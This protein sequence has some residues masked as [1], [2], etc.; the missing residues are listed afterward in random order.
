MP[1]TSVPA[2]PAGAP[3]TRSR[4]LAGLGRRIWR[5]GYRHTLIA[6]AFAVLLAWGFLLLPP[7]NSDLAAQLARA[8]FAS[9]YP[10]SIIDFRWFG[11][12][13]EY[14]Y[15]LWASA[16]MAHLGTK[17]TGALAAVV[18]TWYTTRLLN[19][20]KPAR[21]V[22]GGMAAAV[23]QVANVVEGRI[24]FAC[25]LACGLVAITLFTTRRLPRWLAV[26]LAVLFSLL[27]GGASPVAALLLWV[28]GGVALLMRRPLAAVVL[29]V[30]SGL[31][32]AVTSVIFG[33][34]GHQPF[35]FADC[36]KSLAA[37]AIVL[38]TVPRRCH[39][40][41]LGAGIGMLLL[42]AAFLLPTPV[43]S[44]A[45]RLGVLFALPVAAAFVHWHNRLLTALALVGIV[46]LQLPVN[47]ATIA[48]T[49]RVSGYSAYYTALSEEIRSRGALTGRVEV[50]EMAG[51]WDSVYLARGVPL[52]RGWL[53]QTDVR[54]NDA[55]FYKRKPTPESYRQFLTDNAVQYVAVPDAELTA[56]GRD[57][58]ALIA[59]NL[60]YLQP[61]WRN[62][63]WTLY[64]VADFAAL[65]DPPARVLSQR[66]DAIVV[67]VPANSSI[68]VRLRWYRWLGMES[69]DKQACIAQDGLYVR[70]NTGPAGGNYTFNSRFPI[71]TGHC[72]KS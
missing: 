62:A 15:T 34:G 59:T 10:V 23:T 71:G 2:R 48:S 16:L 53:R 65:V 50:P 41:R 24:T 17:V 45:T 39:P 27:C 13:V 31:T 25:G 28:A 46:A 11:G 44:N 33:D 69:Q 68:R 66:P 9:R 49:G 57:E 32:M 52:A 19:R 4:R 54:L 70:L 14:G 6:T 1:V 18:G 47:P 35:T 55:V 21:P 26:A 5:S 30:P 29:I 42:L 56:F 67:S 8:D 38:A 72:P 36:L 12:T 3:P 43:G 7:M 61:I 63:H 51:H 20:L 64:E 37:L 58:L 40:I 60:P 22:L